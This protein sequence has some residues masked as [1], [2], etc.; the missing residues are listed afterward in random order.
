MIFF[1]DPHFI[2][3][4]SQEFILN[5][6]SLTMVWSFL[7]SQIMNSEQNYIQIIPSS[8]NQWELNSREIT[9]SDD[10]SDR[11]QNTILNRPVSDK[12]R[13]STTVPSQC[14]YLT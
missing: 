7:I 6:I 12:L 11:Y 1:T 3:K 10:L 14:E 4:S 5:Q 8:N 2:Y 9:G 13:Q